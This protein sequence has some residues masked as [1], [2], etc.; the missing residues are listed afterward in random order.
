MNKEQIIKCS[1]KCCNNIVEVSGYCHTCKKIYNKHYN[2]KL[3]HKG[4]YLY[5]ILGANNEVEY[6]GATENLKRRI[7]YQHLKGFSHIRELMRSD[8]WEVIK[9][10][11]VSDLVENREELLMLENALIDLYPNKYN[12]K[13]SIIRNIDKLRE[14][15]LLSEVHSLTQKWELYCTREERGG[16]GEGGGEESTSCWPGRAEGV[17][18]FRALNEPFCAHILTYDL[19]PLQ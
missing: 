14:F 16:E 8:K 10:L 19:N 17:N 11:D 7:Q 4:Y 18:V 9:Y 1:N 2:E 6:I 15:I 3:K 5:V 13:K 12:N